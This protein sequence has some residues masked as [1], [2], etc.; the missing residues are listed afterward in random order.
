[1]IDQERCGVIVMLT[2]LQEGGREKCSRY[3]M[4]GKDSTWDIES[5]LES[6]EIETDAQDVN[7]GP[8]MDGQSSGDYFSTARAAAAQS[9]A[10]PSAASSSSDT[11]LVRRLIRAKRRSS[12]PGSA[13]RKVRHLHYRAWPDFDLPASPEDIVSLIREV[14]E[15]Q[16]AYMQEIGWTDTEREPPILAHCSAGVGRT[17]V[18]IMVSTV[19]DKLRRNRQ[20][21][22]I[23]RSIPDRLSS[24][25]HAGSSPN[26]GGGRSTPDTVGLTAGFEAQSLRS[27]TASPVLSI[28]VSDDDDSINDAKDDEATPLGRRGSAKRK[29]LN[30]K[31]KPAAVPLDGHHPIFEAANEMR[32]SR[33]SM[34]A[35]YRQYVCVHECV[36]LGVLQDLEAGR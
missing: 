17:G 31:E 28:D 4:P 7:C 33:M 22:S 8:T 21:M 14:D 20:S 36:L 3:W 35:N 24:P 6:G 2:N 32:E 15:A 18:F 25:V 10:A 1:M 19:L 16:R 26:G 29:K 9:T 11:H 23:P 30:E 34:I 12:P 13:P 27:Q 5:Q